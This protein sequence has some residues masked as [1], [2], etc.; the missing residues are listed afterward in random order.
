VA[1]SAAQPGALCYFATQRYGDSGLVSL[2]S[3]ECAG[4]TPPTRNSFLAADSTLEA[5]DHHPVSALGGAPSTLT[6]A[7]GAGIALEFH[8]PDGR[9]EQLRFEYANAQGPINTASPLP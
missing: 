2:P 4:P 7:T 6:G 1:R 3:R 9:S 8:G 5:T